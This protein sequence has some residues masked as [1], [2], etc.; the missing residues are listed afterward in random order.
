M[1]LLRAA[2]DR[3]PLVHTSSLAATVPYSQDG[4]VNEGVICDPERT[5][6]ESC[7]DTLI[8]FNASNTNNCGNDMG[9]SAT[10]QMGTQQYQQNTNTTSAIHAGNNE[11]EYKRNIFHET[12]NNGMY[13]CRTTFFH[14][15]IARKIFADTKI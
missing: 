14:S 7:R 8:Q 12:H 11:F 1:G 13:L 3:S 4:Y 5:F 10:I 2:E 6:G 9:K 15:F